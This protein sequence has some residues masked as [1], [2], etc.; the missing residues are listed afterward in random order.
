MQIQAD[1][2]G[3]PVARSTQLETTAYGAAML[4][5]IGSGLLTSLDEVAD[6]W[7]A[8]KVFT[9][10]ISSDERANQMRIW[11]DAVTR[12]RGWSGVLSAG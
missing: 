9:P 6:R 2:T 1:L 10:A 8:D 11:R 12:S 3:V 7:T 4:A 5:A